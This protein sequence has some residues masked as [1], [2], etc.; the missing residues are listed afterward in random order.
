M[1]NSSTP[2]AAP[3]TPNGQSANEA[4][5]APHTHGTINPQSAP[6]THAT[7][8]TLSAP[9]THG[10]KTLEDLLAPISERLGHTQ[11]PDVVKPPAHTR[12]KANNPAEGFV[13]PMPKELTER[14]M[15]EAGAIRIHVHAC[16]TTELAS[17]VRTLIDETL[18]E[19]A[20]TG[21]LSPTACHIVRT[22]DPRFDELGLT[23]DL[24]QTY[25]MREFVWDARTPVQSVNQAAHAAVGVTFADA[26]IAETGTIVQE[27][28]EQNGRAVSLLPET[29]IALVN[30]HDIVF[31]MADVLA[32]YQ[33]EEAP[34]P[35]QLMF[36]SGPSATADIELVRVEGVHGP[37]NVHYV[38]YSDD[39][40]YT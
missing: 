34:L 11:I 21:E 40:L 13:A 7:D 28:S 32:R 33:H 37:M 30:A 2:N 22:A 17:T 38:V 8:D 29:H 20:K 26:A 24:H 5:S 4:Q 36:I 16:K 10:G 14:F 12:R 39:G 31:S 3:P 18:A 25:E 27:A 19:A 23:S 15:A 9:R 6:Q 35:S 1:T